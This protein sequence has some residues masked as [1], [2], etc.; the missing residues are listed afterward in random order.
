M[1]DFNRNSVDSMFSKILERLDQQDRLLHEIRISQVAD[2]GRISTLEH[3]KWLQRGFAAAIG[4][5]ATALWNF[6]TRQR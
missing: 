5:V 3:E 1:S 4:L 2:S 6:L